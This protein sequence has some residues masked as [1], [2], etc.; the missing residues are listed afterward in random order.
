MRFID[1]TNNNGLWDTGNYSEHKLP[2]PLRYFKSK[3]NQSTF[4]LRA[5]WE[6]DIDVDYLQ[7]EE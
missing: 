4:V 6:Y 2:E 7:L 3:T 1:D 5:N